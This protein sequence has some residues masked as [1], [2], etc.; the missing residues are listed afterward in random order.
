MTTWLIAVYCLASSVCGDVTTLAR[1]ELHGITEAQCYQVKETL[2]LFAE[3]HS[4]VGGC[5]PLDNTRA[6]K[7]PSPDGTTTATGD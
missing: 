3:T 7:P 1:I 5:V 6:P 4:M 2:R